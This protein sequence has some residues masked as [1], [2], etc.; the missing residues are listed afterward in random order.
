MKVTSNILNYL[1]VKDSELT[2]LISL[3]FGTF[4]ASKKLPSS[5]EIVLINYVINQMGNMYMSSSY[6]SVLRHN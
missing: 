2:G 6:A 3:E 5:T 4:Y 1:V